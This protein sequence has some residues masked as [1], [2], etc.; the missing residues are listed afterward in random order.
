[1]CVESLAEIDHHDPAI[2][3]AADN[4]GYVHL[5]IE[6]ETDEAMVSYCCIT[7]D[8]CSPRMSILK[9]DLELASINVP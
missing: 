9:G 6:D 3:R 7:T 8:R 2:M 4:A 5:N 1:M